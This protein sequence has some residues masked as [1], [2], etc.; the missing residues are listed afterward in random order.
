M[1]NWVLQFPEALVEDTGNKNGKRDKING[2]IKSEKLLR[3]FRVT[4]QSA[5]SE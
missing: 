2:N 4:L 5:L 1:V 3:S